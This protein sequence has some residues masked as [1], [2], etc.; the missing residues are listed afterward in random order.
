MS[1]V[2]AGAGG[3]AG[4][5]GT[6]GESESKPGQDAGRRRRAARR[7]VAGHSG[8]AAA[9]ASLAL[10]LGLL[11]AVAARGTVHSPLPAGAQP[12]PLTDV[13]ETS[14]AARANPGN[15]PRPAPAPPPAT[16][17]GS[18][19]DAAPAAPY[20]DKI[21][22]R[23]Y[24]SV[25]VIPDAVPFAMVGPDNQVHGFDVAIAEEIAEAIF[26]GSAGAG[27]ADERAPDSARDRVRFRAVTNAERVGVVRD[28]SVDMAVATMTITCGRLR[29]VDFSTVYYESGQRVL[30]R[31][32]S[33]F[34]SLRDLAG[35]RVCAAAATTSIRAIENASPHPIPYPVRNV[36]DCLVA[37]QQ[38]RV[39]AVSTDEGILVGMREQDPL[40]TTLVGPRFTQEPY[41]IAINKANPD[42]TGFVNGVLAKIKG[43]GTW[44]ALYQTWF[45]E[46]APPPPPAE[47]MVAG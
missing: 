5:A 12:L 14:P 24:L 17:P 42:L 20:V 36:S 44:A 9:A 38:G 40:Y 3:T 32:G 43:D 8:R 4:A 34:S 10:A 28:G 13:S 30:V 18:G 11:F 16:G 39:D 19:S 31:T 2:P 7:A 46:V 15:C 22:K 37:L 26:A 1:G 33:G 29:D 35:R 47:V 21:R 6:A 41:G 23:G 27:P 25:A 45:G